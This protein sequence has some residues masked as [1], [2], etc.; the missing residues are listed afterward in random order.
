MGLE[1][2]R[3]LVL[4]I[5]SLGTFGIAALVP[6]LFSTAV[7]ATLVAGAVV[8]G[9]L[10]LWV[11]A[12]LLG[13]PFV[14][15]LKAKLAALVV[16]QKSRSPRP[17]GRPWYGFGLIL[18]SLCFVTYYIAMAIPFLQLSKFTELTTIVVLAIAGELLFVSSFVCA[19]RRILGTDQGSIPTAMATLVRDAGSRRSPEVYSPCQSDG[20][21]SAVIAM[22]VVVEYEVGE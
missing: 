2:L 7:A 4:F 10:G 14:D 19:W 20:S 9:E 17:V 12:A 1:V 21:V 8:S 18:F 3:R 13:R 5:Y 22:E 6:F 11:D 15:A 16:R